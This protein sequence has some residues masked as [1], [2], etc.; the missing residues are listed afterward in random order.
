[1]CLILCIVCVLSPFLSLKKPHKSPL[2]QKQ[3]SDESTQTR[4][5]RRLSISSSSTSTITICSETNRPDKNTTKSDNNYQKS[6]GGS[7]HYSTFAALAKSETSAIDS[8]VERRPTA[9]VETQQRKTKTETT[10][11][12]S[13]HNRNSLFYLLYLKRVCALVSCRSKPQLNETNE[14]QQGS[15]GGKKQMTRAA[16]A[17]SLESGG[18]NYMQ[19]IA[20]PC[21]LKPI[22]YLAEDFEPLESEQDD[23]IAPGKDDDDEE[24]EEENFHKS[25]LNSCFVAKRNQQ[26]QKQQNGAEQKKSLFKIDICDG[27][28][29][30][31]CT[32][33]FGNFG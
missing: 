5:K 30:L 24:E 6:N 21:R 16:S 25:R 10:S 18:S 12:A 33:V 26:A 31:L 19:P 22:R 17:S 28:L 2:K 29:F 23:V 3:I 15:S 7:T 20:Y 32:T 11:A 13:K 8:S 9:V 14:N 1:M 4:Q 27:S